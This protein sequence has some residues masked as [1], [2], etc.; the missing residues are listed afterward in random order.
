MKLY[1]VKKKNDF[2]KILA[3]HYK[4]YEGILIVLTFTLRVRGSEFKGLA[5]ELD[6]V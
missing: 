5:C 1:W 2:A 6:S 3:V 4:T